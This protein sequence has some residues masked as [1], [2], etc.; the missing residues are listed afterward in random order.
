M[1]SNRMEISY[2]GGMKNLNLILFLS[3]WSCFLQAQ[4]FEFVLKDSKESESKTVIETNDSF[5]IGG[6][7]EKPES[8]ATHAFV[9]KLEDKGDTVWTRKI[10]GT[11]DEQDAVVDLQYVDNQKFIVLCNL[12][13][14]V[15]VSLLD[16]SGKEQWTFTDTLS[17][18]AISITQTKGN[19]IAFCTTCRS[20]N[21]NEGKRSICITKLDNTGKHLWSKFIGQGDQVKAY[22]IAATPNGGILVNAWHKTEVSDPHLIQLDAEG[23]VIW[24]KTIAPYGIEYA[25]DMKVDLDG[26]IIVA[27]QFA[28]QGLPILV[29]LDG[30]GNLLWKQTYEYEGETGNFRAYSLALT[31]DKG[32][33]L[34]G[35]TS[36]AKGFLLKTDEKGN[37]QWLQILAKF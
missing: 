35:R 13:E 16:Q 15:T 19:G 10:S 27:G 22:T 29:K 7:Y 5:I 28:D 32:Y 21:A 24:Q 20:E 34:V 2:F 25:F 4:T 36:S 37:R 31:R 11:S 26:N 3:M 14:M 17:K 1:P 18:N 23:K 33:V 6:T 8:W 30:E 12:N 9:I